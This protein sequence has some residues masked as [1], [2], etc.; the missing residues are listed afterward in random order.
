LIEFIEAQLADDERRHPFCLVTI[1][2]ELVPAANT[3]QATETVVS[4]TR[5]TLRPA[6]LLFRSGQ[7]EFVALLLN[8]ELNAATAISLR[9]A[10]ALGALKS[11]GVLATVK[12]GL[13]CAPLD[14]AEA[15]R[16]LV[17]SRERVI[18]NDTSDITPPGAIH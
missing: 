7:D 6:D 16:L 9:V 5:R 18:N 13:A 11:T 1:Q 12:I 8:T 2:F 10:S 3:N 4:A 14:A 17:V 15:E